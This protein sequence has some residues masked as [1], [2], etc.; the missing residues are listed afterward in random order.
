M[1]PC[2][3]LLLRH[4]C[5]KYLLYVYFVCLLLACGNTRPVE[6]TVQTPLPTL[7]P[8]PKTALAVSVDQQTRWLTGIPCAPPCWEG[9][10]PG[11]TSVQ[12]AIELLNT[13]PY[14]SDVAY[15][16]RPDDDVGVI[17]WRWNDLNDGGVFEYPQ[18]IEQDNS[19]VRVSWIDIYFARSVSLKKIREAYGEP[20]YIVPKKVDIFLPHGEQ[21]GYSHFYELT[22]VYLEHG[23]FVEILRAFDEP[24]RLTPNMGLSGRVLFFPAGLEGLET[25]PTSKRGWQT[26]QMIPWQGF[27]GFSYYC[28]QAT[29]VDDNSQLCPEPLSNV[30]KQS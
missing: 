9:I 28:A 13:N 25:V 17:E 2:F 19:T 3:C 26:S 23:F 15:W 18:T 12:E 30:D 6:S 24:P 4:R 20:S 10:T 14:V 11:E 29:P 1:S 22:F 27:L 5:M 16:S 7:T 8:P 21:G